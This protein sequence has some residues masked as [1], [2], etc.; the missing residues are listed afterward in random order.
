[1]GLKGLKGNG[2]EGL[3]FGVMRMF[4]NLIVMVAQLSEYTKN[5]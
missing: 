4:W 5:H 2:G 3:I 1:M